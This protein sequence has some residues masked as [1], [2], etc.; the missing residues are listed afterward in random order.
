VPLSTVRTRC[1]IANR[2]ANK[3]RRGF[4]KPNAPLNDGRPRFSFPPA[5]PSK[6]NHRCRVPYRPAPAEVRQYTTSPDPPNKSLRQY[7]TSP[8]PLTPVSRRFKTA[9]DPSDKFGRQYTTAYDP[10]DKFRRSYR[11]AYDPPDKFRT[12]YKTSSARPPDSLRQ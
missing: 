9:P 12:E 3:F 11:T 8:D 10:P 4:T 1:G 5:R 2:R 7:R 6:S